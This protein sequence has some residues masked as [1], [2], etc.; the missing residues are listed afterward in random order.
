MRIN[1]V[2]QTPFGTILSLSNDLPQNSVGNFLSVDGI[3]L[4][5]IKGTPSD[6]WT[7]VL[8]D[9]TDDIKIGQ[10]VKILKVA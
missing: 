9:K 8:I 7:E 1:N 2:T 10:E 6:I 4:H 3:N 5:Q